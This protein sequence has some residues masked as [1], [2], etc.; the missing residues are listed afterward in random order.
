LSVA[1]APSLAGRARVCFFAHHDSDG[2]V[3]AHVLHYLTELNRA[4]FAIVFVTTSA[5]TARA[6]I[7]VEVVCH[8]VLVRENEGLDFG[9]WAAAFAR[10]GGELRGELL[11][12]NDSVYGPLGDLDATLDTLLAHDADFF[13]LVENLEPSPH[14]QS[15]F[16]LLRPRA[17]QSAA[18]RSVLA[19]PFGRMTKHEIIDAGEIGLTRA[20]IAAGLRYGA[21]V[22]PARIGPLW[23]TLPFNPAQL[24]WRELVEAGLLPFIKV[25]VLRDNPMELPDVDAWETVVAS[26]SPEMVGPIRDHLIRINGIAASGTPM[27]RRMLGRIAPDPVNF[28][29]REFRFAW[30]ARRGAVRLNA[31]AF[32]VRRSLSSVA[33]VLKRAVA[34]GRARDR[35]TGRSD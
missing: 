19:L 15:W 29:R 5:L 2:D 17:Y 16:V 6:A 7:A 13:G 32:Y 10:Y 11:L 24:L 1:S 30:A 12:A 4:G 20:L 34:L 27:P 33:S 31:A 3:A 23:R 22:R 21:A 18:F 35:R 25:E 14:L 8:A 9:S 26:A 28:L